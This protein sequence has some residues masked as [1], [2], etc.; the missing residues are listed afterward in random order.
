MKH[1]P[2]TST[3]RKPSQKR[4]GANKSRREH[5]RPTPKGGNAPLRLY[6]L[7][8]VR[9][10]LE[11]PLRRKIRLSGSPNAIA[12]L[13]P[14][15]EISKI[16]VR[17]VEPRQLDSL[18][19]RDAVHQGVVLECFPLD[20]LD[21]SE[22]FQLAEADLLLVLDQ[23]TDP[24]NVGAILRSAVAMGVDA[25]LITHRN[26]AVET[27]ALA[28]SASGAV[29]MI[30]LIDIRHLSKALDELNTLGFTTI[31]LDSEGPEVLEITLQDAVSKKLAIVL[32]SEGK[33][34][35]EKTRTSCSALARLDMPGAIK[36]LN[37]SNAAALALY[38]TAAHQRQS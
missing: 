25:V 19:A 31:G 38:L 20:S 24:H 23:I 18:V 29:D 13:G 35:R 3:Q 33:G 6:G 8:T 22:L 37:V 26:S 11:N 28:K 16:D 1:P 5:H 14:C 15:V 2:K 27:A 17:E 30:R 34:L 36:S 9:A 12:R 4:T 21:A 10:A 7:H 32:G